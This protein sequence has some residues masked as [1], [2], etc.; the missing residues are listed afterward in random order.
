MPPLTFPAVSQFMGI[1]SQGL[2]IAPPD[3]PS[4]GYMFDKGA[5]SRAVKFET[6]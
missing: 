5:Y 4:S 2:R 3:A 1:L 6:G